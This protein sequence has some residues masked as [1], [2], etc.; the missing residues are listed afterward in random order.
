MRWC[1]VGGSENCVSVARVSCVVN[2]SNCGNE[3]RGDTANWMPCT[4]CGK[5]VW[6]LRSKLTEPKATAT[7]AA[8][9]FGTC[10]C[11][12][13]NTHTQFE[14]TNPKSI[15]DICSRLLLMTWHFAQHCMC[16]CHKGSGNNEGRSRIPSYSTVAT[17]AYFQLCCQ[18]F[19]IFLSN[20]RF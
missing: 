19:V 14:L 12:Q 11:Q 20:K 13:F 16:V 7:V 4:A 5:V 1:W 8:K 15:S 10:N 3:T 9:S 18:A 17:C 6:A 2:S